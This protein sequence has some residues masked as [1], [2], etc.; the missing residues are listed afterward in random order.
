MLARNSAAD[1][2]KAIGY[3][4]QAVSVIQ[5]SLDSEEVRSYLLILLPPSDDTRRLIPWTSVS[6]CSARRTTL[7]LSV[8]SQ[9]SLGLCFQETDAS[10]RA[11]AL[12]EA[13]RWFESSTVICRFVPGGKERAEKVRV[14]SDAHSVTDVFGR[15]QKHTENC[16]RDMDLIDRICLVLY[17]PF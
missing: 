8:L 14:F 5:Q 9:P 6:G 10:D 7:D 2:S 16:F 3:V 12:D 13:K 11:S 1:R 4:E 17:N 15:F